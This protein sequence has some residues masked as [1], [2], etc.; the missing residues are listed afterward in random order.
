MEYQWK[1]MVAPP[2]TKKDYQQTIVLGEAQLDKTTIE[3]LRI[4]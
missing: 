1:L 3:I 4:L 2:H